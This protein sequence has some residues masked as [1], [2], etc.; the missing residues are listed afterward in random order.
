MCGRPQ[1]WLLAWPLDTTSSLLG[2]CFVGRALLVGGQ[3]PSWLASCWACSSRCVWLPM[4]GLQR[5]SWLSGLPGQMLCSWRHRTT[6]M[7]TCW[8][9]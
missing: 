6:Q 4:L 5:G 2:L 8:P 1:E 7:K 3:V 9:R